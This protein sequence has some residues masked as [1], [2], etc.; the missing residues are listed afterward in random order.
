[1]PIH[2]AC[3]MRDFPYT[4]TLRLQQMVVGHPQ[5]SRKTTVQSIV[6]TERWFNRHLHF[7]I[8]HD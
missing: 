5:A 8:V 6:C 2:S 3:N 7:C 4:F 1:M